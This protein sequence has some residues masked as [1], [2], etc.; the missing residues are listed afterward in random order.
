[1]TIYECLDVVVILTCVLSI[2]ISW[3]FSL[4]LAHYWAIVLNIRVI[5]TSWPMKNSSV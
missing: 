2:I 1:M 5:S 4:S 3:S